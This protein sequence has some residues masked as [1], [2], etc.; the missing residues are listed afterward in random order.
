MKRFFSAVCFLLCLFLLNGCGKERATGDLAE[1][2]LN[3]YPTLP[4]YS[5]YV[6]NGTPYEEGY[7]SPEDF[8][9]LYVGE[10]ERLP[11]WDLIEEFSIVLSDTTVPLELH[12]LKARSA[13]DT[14][15]IAKLLSRRAELIRLH[16]KTEG[17]YL[18]YEP[19]LYVNG[20]YAILLVTEDN[21]IAL[22]V[23][24]RLL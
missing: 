6:K 5:I 18:A 8:S 20:R 2:L 16:N 13:T 15:E 22:A 7:L 23:L 3:V 19:Y 4:P 10:K 9:Y 14:D 11:E 24:K 21:D 1:H 12:I 17:D